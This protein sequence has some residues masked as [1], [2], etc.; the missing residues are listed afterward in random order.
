MKII[1]RYIAGSFLSSYLLLLV[2]CIGLYIFGDILANFDN[3]MQDETLT[4]RQILLNMADYYGHNLPLYYHQLGWV[5]LGVAAGFTFAVM[6]WNNEMVALV[7]AGVPLQRL[8]V[9]ALA[10]SVFLIG[11]W[12]ANAEFVLPRFAQ[13]IARLHGDLDDQRAAFIQYVRDDNN[14]VLVAEEL[15]LQRGALEGVHMIEPDPNGGLRHLIRADAATW[16]PQRQ[17]WALTRGAR[18]VV[19]RGAGQE[20]SALAVRWDPL[21]EY[22]FTLSPDEIL[23]RQSSQWADLMSMREMNEL[24]KSRNLPNLA[25]IDRSRDVRFMQP[26]VAWI[27]MLLG[28]P[29]FL[30]REPANVFVAG[31]KALLLSGTCFAFIFLVQNLWSDG[32]TRFAAALPL[33]VFGPIAVFHLGNAK[34]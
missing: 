25:A 12:V 1:D 7:A 19:T 22:P 20:G 13:K 2:G 14:V 15:H 5:L 26:L 10:C 32:Y 21:D 29:F 3:F 30:T 17:V 18:Q 23:L 28:M 4:T 9:P 31:A 6:L 8:A 11:G 27:M 24:L 33:L 16:D 34:T